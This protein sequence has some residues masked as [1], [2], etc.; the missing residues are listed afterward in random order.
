MLL[1]AVPLI[2]ETPYLL[3]IWLKNVPAYTVLFVRL[4]LIIS[5]ISTLSTSLYTLVISTGNIKQYQIIVGSLGLS[6]F[7]FTYVLY[8]FD[9]PVETTY[10][11]SICINIIILFARLFILSKQTG[12]NMARYLNKVVLRTII[13]TIIVGTLSYG[14]LQI[15]SEKTFVNAIAVVIICELFTVGIIILCGLSQ[16]ERSYLLSFIFKKEISI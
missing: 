6:C 15:F 9:A 10:Y 5:L 2:A 4:T 14:V 8:K 13:V 12:L 3:E 16:Y 11:V 1:F 7:F